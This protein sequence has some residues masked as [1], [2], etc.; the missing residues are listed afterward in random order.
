[1]NPGFTSF[2]RFQTWVSYMLYRIL[3]WWQEAAGQDNVI[4]ALSTVN[5]PLDIIIIN[6]LFVPQYKTKQYHK[7]QITN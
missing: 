6:I 2:D 1:M 4:P 3:I 7:L 5:K